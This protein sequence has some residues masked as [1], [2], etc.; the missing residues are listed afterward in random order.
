MEVKC[1]GCS[2]G[3]GGVESVSEVHEECVAAPSE[4]ILDVR[5]GELGL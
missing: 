4:A 5:V 2:V 3:A 1:E